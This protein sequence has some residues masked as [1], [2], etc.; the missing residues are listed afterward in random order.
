[1]ENPLIKLH[2]LFALGLMLLAASCQ[3]EAEV[4]IVETNSQACL[5][6]NE[7]LLS[8]G[9]IHTMDAENNIVDSVRVVNDSGNRQRPFN[10]LWRGD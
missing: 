10:N 5:Q 3:Q 7:L 4:I 2:N 8:N 6:V 9:S 1:M